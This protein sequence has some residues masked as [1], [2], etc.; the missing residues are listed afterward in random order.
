[1]VMDT[2]DCLLGNECRGFDQWIWSVFYSELSCSEGVPA[3]ASVP[4]AIYIYLSEMFGDGSKGGTF[5][6]S[7]K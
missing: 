5:L 3:A 6:L 4:K 2:E 1:M 7:K